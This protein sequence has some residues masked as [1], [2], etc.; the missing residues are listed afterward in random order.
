MKT[1]NLT[2]ARRDLLSAIADGY[3]RLAASPG[4]RRWYI[5]WADKYAAPAAQRWVVEQGLAEQIP[6]G[7]VRLTEAG[8]R[9]LT[10]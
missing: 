5:K 9:A 7:A 4:S 8:Q 3:V 6:G 1:M 2:P 10:D